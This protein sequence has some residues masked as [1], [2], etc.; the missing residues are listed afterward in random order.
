[1]SISTT[2]KNLLFVFAFFCFSLHI[3]SQTNWELLNPK[4]SSNN[5]LDIRFVSS[6]N[7]YIINSNE[8]L[9]TLDAGISWRKKQN[10]NSGNDL[11]F[12]NT[13]GFIV[14]NNGLV[15]KSINGGTSWSQISTGFSDNFNTV[16][17]INETDII[18]SS[19]NSIIKSS[20][21]GLTWTNKTIP[22]STVNKTF[23]VT[24][25]IGHAACNNGTI[26]KTIDGGVNWYVTQ[27]SNSFPSNLLMVYFINQNIGFYTKEHSD[28]YKTIDG[29]ETWSKVNGISDAIYALSFVN[30]SIGYA[31]G[32]YG[33]LFKTI[34][35]GTTWQWAGFQNGR[36][37]GTNMYGIHFLDSNVGF[38]TGARGRIIKTIDGGKT[39]TQNSPTYNDINKIHFFDSG[40][41]YAQVRSD[42]FKT[43]NS[44]ENWALISTANHFSY[45]SN[46]YFV[47][48]NIGYSIGDGTTSA[49][50]DVFKTTNGG[51][52]WN[53]LGIEVDEGLSSVFFIDENIGFISGGFNRK[54]T[55]K[56]IDGGTSWKEVITQ[57]FGQIQFL[58]NQIG[59]ANRIG[60]SGGRIYKTVD[61]GTTWTIN[62]DVDQN[63]K[64]IHFLDENNGYFIGDNSLM[65]KTKNGGITWEKLTIPYG[66]YTNL[67]FYSKNV[68]YI[69]TE[70]GQMYKTIN[71]G[72][73][74]ENLTG[75]TANTLSF[76]D[77]TIYAAGTNGKILKS[78]ISFNPISVLANPALN[79]SNKGAILSGNVASNEGLIQNIR[80]EYGTNYALTNIINTNP[81][82]VPLNSSLNISTDLTNLRPNTTYFYK[83]VATYNNIDYSSQTL[84]FTTL[85]DFVVS[86]N[87]IYT[88]SS[89]TAEV[90]GNIK[91][92]ENEISNIEFQ[93]G[94]KAD[95][96][97]FSISP[98]NTLVAGNTNQNIT[99]NLSNLIPETTYYLRIKA[100]HKGL[101]IYSTVKSFKTKP[102]YT[103]NLYGSNISGN[104]ATLSA[105]ITS[106]NKNITNIVFEYGTINY[107]NSISTVI[108]QIPLNT[109]NTVSATITN[110]DPNLTYYYRIKALNGTDIIYSKGNVFNTSGNVIMV[111][112]PTMEMNSAINFVGLIN[113][114]GK[115]LTNIQFEYGLTDSYGS[116][117]NGSPNYTFGYETSTITATATN[118]LPNKTYFYRLIATDNGN[119][120]YS[121]KYQ[122]TT[123][124][125]NIND[126]D[127]DNNKII[128][129]PNPTNDEVNIT[130][131]GIKNVVSVT[132]IDIT[133][134]VLMVQDNPN[135]KNN[136]KIIVSNQAKGT[137]IVKVLFSDN[138]ISSQK[139]LLK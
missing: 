114:N 77:K 73:S 125:L 121:S 134:K 102:E 63:I 82:S 137:Y 126:F 130:T 61:G 45:C 22:N 65:Y 92:N 108:N 75:I 33:V 48:E 135:Q 74:W 54:K 68:G 127:I 31:T 103:I 49:S 59:Y 88:Y 85:P 69:I 17:I 16:N 112:N 10:I 15:L 42:Y 56:T 36:Y 57:E 91:S 67:K 26:L 62:I 95:F 118:L 84:S 34:D 39:W 107:E 8:I 44:G 55:L 40:I 32:E 100:L 19:S 52:T 71:G 76:V 28:M 110:L 119:K 109:A 122:F 72:I 9:E 128:L 47:N 101:N 106:Y 20:D 138:T 113:G 51:T 2:F 94:T 97:E 96:T 41:G 123:S 86:I 27:S 46:S 78:T 83:L 64:S 89:N 124:T 60:Y 35:G 117:I 21:G 50:G 66:Y 79:L 30:E 139:L 3:N 37:G 133:G 11:N 18:I 58:N 136:F 7:G 38:A 87:D 99:S 1:M 111:S 24:P 131:N 70:Y 12:Y 132:L 25:L 14:G 13:L 80:F 81:N 93:Y 105:Y 116:T 23:F 104:N 43:V 98:L 29:G 129:Y 4:P 53:K 120:L 5:G 115:Y 6:S 90:S